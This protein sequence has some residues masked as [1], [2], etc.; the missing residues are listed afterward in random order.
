M[1]SFLAG[2][3]FGAFT[4]A[5]VIGLVYWFNEEGFEDGTIGHD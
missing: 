2:C 4:L 3:F 1:D 5:A